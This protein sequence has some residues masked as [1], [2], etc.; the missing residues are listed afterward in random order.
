ML[1]NSYIFMLA[2]LPIAV[3]VY[4]LLNKNRLLIAGT[5]WLLFASLV[6]YGWF[7]PKYLLLIFISM[8]FNYAIGSALVRDDFQK[9]TISPKA[10]LAFGIVMNILALAYY[11]Y[12]DFFIS[13]INTVF[14]ADLP[15]LKIAL[16]LAISFI[17][18]KQIAYLS[19]CYKKIVKDYDFLNYCLFICFFPPLISGPIVHYQ[20]I[21]PQFEKLRN[22][23]LSYKN[24]TWGLFM[25]AIGLF[26]KSIMASSFAEIVNTGFVP[27]LE[28]TLFSGWLI[29]VAYAFQ[30]YFDFSGY[31]DMAFGVAKMF[32]IDLPLNF[33]SPYKSDSIQDFWRRWH[34]T[35]GRFLRD[36]IYIPLGGSRVGNVRTYVN[37]FTTFLIGGFWHGASWMFIIWGALQGGGLVIHRLWRKLNIGMPR[38]IAIAITFVF[39]VISFVYFRAAE[40][41]IA[42]NIVKAM[43]GFNGIVLPR[44]NYN[45]IKFLKDGAD[46]IVMSDSVILFAASFILIFFCLNSNEIMARFKFKPWMGYALMLLYAVILLNMSKISEFLYFNF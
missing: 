7:N 2:F 27:G 23:V 1:F 26:K 31:T 37:L 34:I 41:P 43:F 12:F 4:F 38:F 21:M 29:A 33:N 14:H 15:L 22:K 45:T 18:F 13:N 19:D 16:P 6:F 5:T 10:L 3:A 28:V 40:I 9:S 25:F 20:E 24:I 36:Y 11:K 8:M 44:F 17:T 30:L 46:Y 39:S 42:N 32:N 35:L